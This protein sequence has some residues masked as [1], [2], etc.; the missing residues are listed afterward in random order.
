MIFG[1]GKMQR[2]LAS[3]STVAVF[4]IPPTAENT[5]GEKEHAQ[6]LLQARRMLSFSPVRS[7]RSSGTGWSFDRLVRMD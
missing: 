5:N 2:K 6:S 1:H 3:N 4:P 7:F